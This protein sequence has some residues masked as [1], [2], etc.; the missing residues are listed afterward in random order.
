MY[1]ANATYQISTKIKYMLII[2]MI[3]IICIVIIYIRIKGSHLL[4]MRR[5]IEKNLGGVVSPC[6]IISSIMAFAFFL[7]FAATLNR[8]PTF[9]D[10]SYCINR[11]L[12]NIVLY[13]DN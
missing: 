12:K 7:F 5:S 4:Q 11:H 1:I 9:N 6:V 13:G 10:S 2:S 8:F 3:G